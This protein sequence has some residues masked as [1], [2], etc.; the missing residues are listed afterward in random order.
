MKIKILD[1]NPSKDFIGAIDGT[2]IHVIVVERQYQIYKQERLYK[3]KCP[4]N[5][6]F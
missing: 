1:S 5:P 3:S 6:Q 2:Q 4:I